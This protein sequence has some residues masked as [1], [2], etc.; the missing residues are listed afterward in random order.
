MGSPA[1]RVLVADLG[2][3][4]AC[5][6]QQKG[7]PD[8]LDQIGAVIGGRAI[9]AEADY[10][11]CLFHLAH[12]AAAGGED[13]VRA[14]AVCNARLGLAQPYHFSLVE[15]EA[16]SKPS[17]RAEPAALLQIVERPA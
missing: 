6:L 2:H 14:G 5:P 12:R 9:N 10:H 1:Q 16:V 11:T 8:L 3:A 17:A 4:I 15:V 13:L 7:R